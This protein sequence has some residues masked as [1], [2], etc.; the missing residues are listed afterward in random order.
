[1]SKEPFGYVVG[2]R[3]LLKHVYDRDTAQHFSEQWAASDGND[4]SYPV[5]ALIDV[6]DLNDII[7]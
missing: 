3:A 4:A 5:Y 6:D 2:T 7:E 1:M